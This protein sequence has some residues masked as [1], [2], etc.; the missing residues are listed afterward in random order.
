MD[1]ELENMLMLQIGDWLKERADLVKRIKE[2]DQ[3]VAAARVLINEPPTAINVDD[4]LK[5]SKKFMSIL[6]QR[7]SMT[8][9]ELFD[10]MKPMSS[11]R[12]WSIVYRQVN[13]TKRITFDKR[14]RTVALMTLTK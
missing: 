5:P 3:K 12:F 7:G 1:N 4:N 14:T 2:I 10:C 6:S 11:K 8:C 9:D 13:E